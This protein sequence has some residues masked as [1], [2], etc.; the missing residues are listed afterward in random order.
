MIMSRH[1]FQVSQDSLTLTLDH[2]VMVATSLLQAGQEFA[3]PHLDSG[4]QQPLRLWKMLPPLAFWLQNVPEGTHMRATLCR[5][6][7]QHPAQVGLIATLES[8]CG[9][10]KNANRC[11]AVCTQLSWECLHIDPVSHSGLWLDGNGKSTWLP[12]Q[13]PQ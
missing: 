7:I 4:L 5:R 6:L 8:R 13:Y 2:R 9:G 12:P 11:D 10:V 1:Y 3:A